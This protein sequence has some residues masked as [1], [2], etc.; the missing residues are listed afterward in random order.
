M[1]INISVSP[2]INPRDKEAAPKFYGKVQTRGTVTFDTLADD[3][4]YATTLT[5]GDVSNVLRAL[6]KQIKKHLADGKI[7]NL[8]GLGT[9]QFQISG[10]G[11]VT[12]KDYNTSLIQKV[13]IQYRPG[14]LVREVQ[15]LTTLQFKKVALLR[16]KA[17]D[18]DE[19]QGGEDLT[20]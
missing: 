1:P 9:F 12:E 18:T 11:A 6:V 15:N 14:R 19:E 10:K 17:V 8:D 3:I 20:D 2:R 16:T 13:R 5:D 4:A 7:V